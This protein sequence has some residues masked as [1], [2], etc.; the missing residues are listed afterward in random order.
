MVWALDIETLGL[1]EQKPLPEITCVCLFDGN[2]E[3][4]LQLY[5]VS[6][7]TRKENVSHL[8]Q[9]L[10]SADQLVGFNAVLFDLEFIKQSFGISDDNMGRWVRKTIDVYMYL[11]YA[12][13]STT[14]LSQLLASNQLPSKTGS[15]KQAISMA[16]EGKFEDLLDYCLMDAKLVYQLCKLPAIVLGVA[17]ESPLLLSIHPSSGKWQ[18]Q[19]QHHHNHDDRDASSSRLKKKRWGNV[20]WCP[21][22]LAMVGG[23][24]VED[25][26]TL[27]H[28]MLLASSTST[29]LNPEKVDWILLEEEEP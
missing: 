25:L 6:P 19:Q 9:L 11:R 22:P 27:T 23:Q 12:L 8:L 29:L 1:L 26:Q 20:T 28:S 24:V 15:G 14:G 18:I 21:L 3:I 17:G 13:T 2:Q 7:A 16:L 5:G 10:D 4:K